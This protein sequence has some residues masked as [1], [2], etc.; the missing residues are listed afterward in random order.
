MIK[1]CEQC[2]CT[3]FE[4]EVDDNVVKICCKE[5]N[6]VYFPNEVITL[7]EVDL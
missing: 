7:Q 2:G 6:T 4:I 5:C 1:C 3:D